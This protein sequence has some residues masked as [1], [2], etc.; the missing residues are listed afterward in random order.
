VT[1]LMPTGQLR[2][3]SNQVRP[4][5]RIRTGLVRSMNDAVRSVALLSN[6]LDGIKKVISDIRRRLAPAGRMRSRRKA[7]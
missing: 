1:F 6:P 2:C 3:R 4:K 7:A 5:G